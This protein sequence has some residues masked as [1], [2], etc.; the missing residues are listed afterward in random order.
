MKL[1]TTNQH[2]P[3][4]AKIH[5]EDSSRSMVFT[6]YAKLRYQATL[7]SEEIRGSFPGSYKAKYSVKIHT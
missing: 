3:L 1:A 4:S 6:L 5:K 2:L 7:N